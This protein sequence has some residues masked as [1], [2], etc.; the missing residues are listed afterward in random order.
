[1]SDYRTNGLIEY[2]L[3][4]GNEG[5]FMVQVKFIGEI[6]SRIAMRNAS[7]TEV[8]TLLDF[9]A[10]QSS[11]TMLFDD[12]IGLVRKISVDLSAKLVMLDVGLHAS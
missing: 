7:L 2:L 4:F 8:T 11:P 9:L 12:R 5:D 6:G 3:F 1:M 10:K